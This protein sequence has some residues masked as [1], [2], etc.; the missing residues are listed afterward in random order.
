MHEAVSLEI[1]YQLP[2]GAEQPQQDEERFRQ[3]AEWVLLKFGLQSI[4]ASISIVNDPTIHRVNREHL[5]HDWPTD[6][7]SFVFEPAPQVQGEI[8]ASSD[9][10]SRL[11]GDAGWR[12]EDELLLYIVH[13]LLHLAG[14]DDQEESQQLEMR[15]AEQECLL[16]LGVSGAAEHLSRWNDISY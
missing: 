6:V 4:V 3:A 1:E 16:A 13:G 10:A 2:A 5:E 8:I 12:H 15:R 9:T 14:L 7:I 11:C